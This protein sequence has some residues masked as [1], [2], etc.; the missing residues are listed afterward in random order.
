[1]RIYKIACV[2][3]FII[4]LSGCNVFSFSSI[5]EEPS[6]N[7]ESEVV[8]NKIHIEN[9]QETTAILHPTIIES[10]I[11]SRIGESQSYFTYTDSLPVKIS[12]SNTG[13]ESFLYKVQ[14]IN[15][16]TLVTSGIL[17]S[18]ENF[19][20]VYDDLPEGGYII[21]AVV[22]EELAP[23]DIKLKVKVELLH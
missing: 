21:S 3:T 15:K 19:E 16:D 2:C 4:L 20:Q 22:Q 8:N 23:I 13:T 14:N 6:L 5:K 9:K 18:N 1:M 17:N 11:L 7:V 10:E 12:L